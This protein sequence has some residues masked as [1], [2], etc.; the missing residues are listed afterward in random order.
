MKKNLFL[1]AITS[2]GL[3]ACGGKQQPAENLDAAA[4]TTVV[5]EAIIEETV[6]PDYV[7]LN[8]KGKVKSYELSSTN[9]GHY[10]DFVGEK[11]EFDENGLIVKVN[12][13]KA[14]LTRNDKGQITNF[15]WREQFEEDDWE[16]VCYIY[17]YD[18]NGQV[19]NIE[20]HGCWAEYNCTFVRDDNGNVTKRINKSPT[21]GTI[22]DKY[23]Y[24]EFDKQ[25][26]W[27]K[28]K[29]DGTITR[30]ITYWE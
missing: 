14:Q 21:E 25:G 30:K 4:D 11:V 24:T 12:N 27:T 2:I 18:E 22:T 15:T 10:W 8:L 26:N 5:E 13:Q 7:M 20:H 29:S 17:T 6:S 3:M 19:T 28:C 9:N 16:D 23:A 1:I